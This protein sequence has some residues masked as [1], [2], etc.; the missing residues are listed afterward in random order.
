MFL[1]ICVL[2]STISLAPV[3]LADAS[4]SCLAQHKAIAGESVQIMRLKAE[5]E[6]LAQKFD[7]ED[8][9][10]AE[11]RAEL[12]MAKA[13]VQV[14]GLE[15]VQDRYD[16]HYG[17]AEALRTELDEVNEQVVALGERHRSHVAKF[18]ADCVQ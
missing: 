14:S 1:R 8:Q 17:A 16:G 4:E 11:L 10:R 13:G 12:D 6:K 18:N 7:R 9:A 3:A 2:A 15:E 5:Q